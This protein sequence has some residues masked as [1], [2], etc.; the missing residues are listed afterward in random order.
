[1]TLLRSAPLNGPGSYS[2]AQSI[3]VDSF[4]AA[5][6]AVPNGVAGRM[7]WV[8]DPLGQ[9]GTVL[10]CQLGAWTPE[11]GT[12]GNRSEINFPNETVTAGNAAPRWYKWSFMVP[13]SPFD[14]ADR[15]FCIA[16]IHDEP[17]GGDGARFPNFILYAGMGDWLVISQLIELACPYRE[18]VCWEL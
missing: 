14:A 12:Y 2:A 15:Y 1:M 9:R 18:L 13:S 17:D 10:R 6:G 8:A 11:S 5:P 3:Q 7:E 16:Q 4:T